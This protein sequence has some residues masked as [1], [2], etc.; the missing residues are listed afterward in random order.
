[1]LVNKS[2]SINKTNNYLSSQIDEQKEDYSMMELQATTWE[3]YNHDGVK[4]VDRMPM[5]FF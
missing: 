2:N 1:M 3:E 4:Q 5:K